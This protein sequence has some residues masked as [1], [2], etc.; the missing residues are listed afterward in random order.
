MGSSNLWSGIVLHLTSVGRIRTL[1]LAK[2]QTH[3]DPESE[4]FDSPNELE[5]TCINDLLILV[6]PGL[7]TVKPALIS[8][9]TNDWTPWYAFDPII[10]GAD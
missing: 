7:A 5:L 10:L 8:N 6:E 3:Y 2:M 9:Q 4:L 1:A